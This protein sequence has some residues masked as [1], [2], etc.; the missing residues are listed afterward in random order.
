MN[1]FF[2]IIACVLLSVSFNAYSQTNLPIK[3]KAKQQSTSDEEGWFS[4]YYFVK[5]MNIVFNG[6]QLYMYYDNNSTF[7]KKEVASYK[8]VVEIDEDSENA[9]KAMIEKYILCLEDESQG[10]DS[11]V[12]IIVDHRYNTD[13]L[14]VILPKISE[15]GEPEGLVAYRKFIEP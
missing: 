4:K 7:L 8:R 2:A 10:T 12:T 3:F 5:P 6:E 11:V 14:E 1:K 15:T 9:Q 13:Y